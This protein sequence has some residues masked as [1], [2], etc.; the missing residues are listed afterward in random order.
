GQLR[1]GDIVQNSRLYAVA[2]TR[3]DRNSPLVEIAEAQTK[4]LNDLA[5]IGVTVEDAEAAADYR[6]VVAEHAPCESETRG[7]VQLVPVPQV[8]A[9]AVAVGE[10]DHADCALGN[11]ARAGQRIGRVRMEVV[12]AAGDVIGGIS[13]VMPQAEVQ[14]QPWSDAPIVLK[15]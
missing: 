2:Q 13:G 6:I 15:R 8:F 14:G 4:L 12:H 9:L 11:V 3:G 7:E 10:S 1:D 5:V